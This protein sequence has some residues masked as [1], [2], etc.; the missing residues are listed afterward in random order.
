ML[1]TWLLSVKDVAGQPKEKLNYAL[2]RFK[3]NLLNVT[4]TGYLLGD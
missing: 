2:V 4:K 3:D 1:A